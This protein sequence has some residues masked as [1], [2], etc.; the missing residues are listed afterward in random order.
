MNT[1]KKHDAVRTVQKSVRKI[2]EKESKSVP[3]THIAHVLC[4]IQAPL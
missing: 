4:L 2:V 3:L 1:K